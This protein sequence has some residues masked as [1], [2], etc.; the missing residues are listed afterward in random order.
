MFQLQDSIL[1]PSRH[2]VSAT[3][4]AVALRLTWILILGLGTACASA[5]PQVAEI[6]LDQRVWQRGVSPETVLIP[7]Q[8]DDEM[9]RWAHRAAPAELPP[10]ERLES[11]AMALLSDGEMT[12]EYSWGFTGTARQVFETR[13]A[14]CLA[15]TNLFLAMAREVGVPVYF[16]AVETETFRRQGEF[17]VISDHIAVGHGP[18][19]EIQM[20]D[21][22]QRQSDELRRVRRIDDLTALAMFHSNRGAEAL[23]REHWKDAL[24]S[25]RLAVRLQPELA[26]GWVNL[27]VARRRVGDY[28]GAEV[29]YRRALEIDPMVYAS[30]QNLASLLRF[31]GRDEEAQQFA[32]ALQR[33]PNRNPFTYISLGDIS[34]RS[35]RFAEARRFYKRAVNL[36]R[37]QAESYAA[38]GQLALMRGDLDTARRML[39]KARRLDDDN[40]RTLRLASMIGPMDS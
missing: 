20:Y 15:F 19:P 12:L 35:G 3:N 24:D 28:D 31:Q 7:F 9:S 4:Q 5:P 39:R 23:Q 14:N 21:F 38:L 37:E 22:S 29:A 17:V 33:T 27:G 1:S 10:S 8:L 16:L 18:G 32:D 30:Y 2:G 6:P 26:S 40:A 34:L 11:L 36:N 13:Q 25:L